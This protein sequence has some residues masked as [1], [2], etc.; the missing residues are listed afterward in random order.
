[1]STEQIF[2][3]NI[4]EANSSWCGCNTNQYFLSKPGDSFLPFE[5]LK[6]FFALTKHLLKDQ[7]KY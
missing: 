5:A 2:H 4:Q 7:I 6:L 3:Y 1:M